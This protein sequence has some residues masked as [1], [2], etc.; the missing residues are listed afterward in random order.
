M[1]KIIYLSTLL[2]MSLL[3]A[4]GQN[5]LSAD[6]SLFYVNK[7]G[8]KRTTINLTG[9][10]NGNDSQKLNNE[11]NRIS[12]LGGGIITINKVPGKPYIYL[13]SVE[14]KNKVHLKI[15]SNVTLK[16][17][18]GGN[19][20]KNVA[21][22][23]LGVKNKVW[24][25]AI[26]NSKQW[27]TNT[28]DY[29]KVILSGGPTERV[30]IVEALSVTNFL[31]SGIKVTD[32]YTIFSNIEC[33]LNKTQ[34]REW[35]DL[36]TNGVIKNVIS[37]KNHVGYGIIQIRAGKKILFK[38]LDGEGGVT[39]RVESGIIPSIQ[40]SEATIDN[41]VGRDITVR[42]GDASVMLSPHRINQG[43]VDISNISAYNSTVAAQI[44][45]GFIDKKGGVDNLG[46]FK[47]TSYIG[48]FNEVRGGN[49]AQVKSKDFKLYPCGVQNSFNNTPWNIDD[50]SK[51][52]KSLTVVRYG[53]HPTN[54]CKTFTGKP[55]GCYNV[56]LQLPLNNKVSGTTLGNSKKIVYPFKDQLTCNPSNM[57]LKSNKDLL[58]FENTNNNYSFEQGTKVEFYNQNGILKKSIHYSEKTNNLDTSGLF[59]GFYILAIHSKDKITRKKIIIQH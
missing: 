34:S 33:N 28:N 25:T 14:L 29:F 37:Y 53:A 45:G 40:S 30:R 38:N 20:P 47:G 10:N 58:D 9:L 51:Q 21:I 49:N 56:N 15:A 59:N 32:S 5:R 54:G 7:I 48:D 17:W 55:S 1:K 11:I 50:E 2:F 18:L 16:P 6:E 13:R 39:L 12:N 43:R 46:T 36:P 3:S 44:E 23:N 31:I 52:G 42:K 27:S 41:I 4:V 22:F 24:N 57:A 8:P 26:T 35:S 19:R